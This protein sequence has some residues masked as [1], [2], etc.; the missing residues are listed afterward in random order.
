[1]AQIDEQVNGWILQKFFSL[2]PRLYAYHT[3]LG[4][5]PEF[6]GPKDGI[7][8]VSADAGWECGCYS[9][10][11]RDDEYKVTAILQTSNGTQ[12]EFVYGS[13]GDFPDF[14]EELGD[15]IYGNDCYYE[16]EEYNSGT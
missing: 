2:Q 3:S 13:W 9:S 5:N 7:T 15:Y 11:T 10:W 1:M 4:Y 14:I 16:S 6:H 12:F 8:V